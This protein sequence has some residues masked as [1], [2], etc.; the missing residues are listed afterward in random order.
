MRAKKM[1]FGESIPS[2]VYLSNRSPWSHDDMKTS[3]EVKELNNDDDDND[4]NNDDDDDDSNNSNEDR[5]N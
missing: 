4:D 5:Q 2:P 3:E 1:S